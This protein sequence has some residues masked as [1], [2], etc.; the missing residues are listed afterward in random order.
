MLRRFR[1]SVVSL[2]FI[3]SCTCPRQSDGAVPASF[4]GIGDLP[5]GGFYSYVTA[6]SPDGG[7]LVG[8]STSAG[9]TEAFRWTKSGGMI[10]LG[11]LPGGPFQSQATSVSDDGG[12]IVGY[13]RTSN[14]GYEAF[15]WTAATGMQLIGHSGGEP[16]SRAWGVSADGNV[17]VGD[18]SL[19][20]GHQAFRWTQQ[21]GMVGIGDIPGG[22]FLSIGQG[23]SAD[24]SVVVGIGN[25]TS[26]D[27]VEAFRW[28]AA[29]GMQSLGD[30]PGGHTTARGYGVSADGSVVVGEGSSSAGTEAFRWTAAT[31]MIGLGGLPGGGFS[32]VAKSL[33]ADGSLIVGNATSASGTLTVAFVWDAAHGMRNLKSVF[34]SD[35]G[36]TLTGWTLHTAVISAD[37]TRFGGFGTN[38]F[39]QSEAWFAV[40]P[41]PTG[42]ALVAAPVWLLSV[43]RRRRRNIAA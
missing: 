23:A 36:I 34:E 7:T 11:D 35:Y 5:G 9:G 22:A 13:S 40:I 15:R 24:G 38:P 32:S 17:I 1:S 16:F 31:G 21:D 4:Q 19:A 30:L 2:L 6:I 28:T 12:L 10:G 27:Q 20:S 3:L 18:A 41:E 14:P 33:S 8:E 25:G 26:A 39:G 37:G 29:T 43:P 42:L